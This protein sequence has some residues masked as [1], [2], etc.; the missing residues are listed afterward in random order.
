MRFYLD[1]EFHEDGKTIE[2]ISLGLVSDADSKLYVQSSEY[3]WNRATPWLIKNVMPSLKS[4]GAGDLLSHKGKPRQSCRNIACPW[5]TRAEIRDEIL[6][7]VGGEYGTPEFWGYYADYDWVVFCQLFGAMVD[8]PDEWPQYCNDLKQLMHMAGV[9][10][11]ELP[12]QVTTN[13]HALQDALWI[14]DAFGVVRTRLNESAAANGV[15][16]L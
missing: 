7:F 12:P 16:L 1:T 11:D 3:D 10:R 9:A 4:C 13:H 2:I 5:R 6:S 14:K 8:L 15:V